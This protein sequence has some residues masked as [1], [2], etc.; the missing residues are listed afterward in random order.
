M[1]GL[2]E[3]KRDRDLRAKALTDAKAQG[4]DAQKLAG[5][6]T[7]GMTAHYTK[8]RTVEMVVPLARK[9]QASA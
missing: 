6:A 3:R 5:H 7:E 4:L 2:K 1:R 8:S 9:Y